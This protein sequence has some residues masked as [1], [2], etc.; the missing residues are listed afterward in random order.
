MLYKFSLILVVLQCFWVV[1]QYAKYMESRDVEKARH[2]FHRSCTIHLPQKASLHLAWA[3]F[4]ERQGFQ[5]V[6]IYQ[7]LVL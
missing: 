2:A 6:D 3:A 1:F 7:C 4:E 5:L